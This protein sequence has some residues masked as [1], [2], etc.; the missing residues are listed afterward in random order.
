MPAPKTMNH[1]A[2]PKSLS[3]QPSNRHKNNKTLTSPTSPISSIN[4]KSFTVSYSKNQHEYD[5]QED[6]VTTIIP[7][8]ETDP[9][10]STREQMERPSLTPD[11]VANKKLMNGL[12]RERPKSLYFASSSGSAPS[13]EKMS[14]TLDAV[15]QRVCSNKIN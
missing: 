11:P 12:A 15:L 8:S 2:R 10:L 7:R 4:P 13:P 1:R 9:S 5:E 14:Q 6:E 3:F